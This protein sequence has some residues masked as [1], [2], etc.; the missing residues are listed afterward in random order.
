M[1]D[2]STEVIEIDRMTELCSAVILKYGL[3]SEVK[4]YPR[5][6]ETRSLTEFIRLFAGYVLTEWKHRANLFVETYSILHPFSGM[7]DKPLMEDTEIFPQLIKLYASIF[8]KVVRSV[9]ILV[10]LDNFLLKW[11]GLLC[12]NTENTKIILGKVVPL[13]YKDGDYWA[14][15]NYKVYPPP[16][17]QPS[18]STDDPDFRIKLF[19]V[20][21]DDQCDISIYVPYYMYNMV[22]IRS[23]NC[24]SCACTH[25]SHDDF[26]LFLA[27][28][29]MFKPN[30]LFKLD[31]KAVTDTVYYDRFCGERVADPP[32][33]A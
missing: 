3:R 1:A 16:P 17:Q 15:R 27:D 4:R 22:S 21:R 29:Q 28:L 25:I 24:T 33:T 5:F 32:S 10:N 2:A 19:S 8:S 18:T 13:F 26:K 12:L 6:P 23:D 30:Q 20:D 7:V 31:A 11:W 9:N 14:V